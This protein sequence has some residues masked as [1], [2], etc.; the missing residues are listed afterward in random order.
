MTDRPYPHCA[1]CDLADCDGM[2]DARVENSYIK[3]A[4]IKPEAPIMQSA[5]EHAL[6]VWCKALKMRGEE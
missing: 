6:M 5:W 4:G 2:I 1:R 3:Y